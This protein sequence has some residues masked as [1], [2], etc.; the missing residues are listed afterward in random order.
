MTEA[1]SDLFLC[2]MLFSKDF[3]TGGGTGSS[4]PGDDDDEPRGNLYLGCYKDS[5][6]DR[7]FKGKFV[8]AHMTTNVRM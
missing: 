5:S 2:L 8:D 6:R 3:A 1:C 7:I 4:S